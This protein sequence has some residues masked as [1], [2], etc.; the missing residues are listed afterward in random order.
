MLHVQCQTCAKV[1]PVEQDF[2]DDRTPCPQCE[3]PFAITPDTEKSNQD[4]NALVPVSV[5]EDEEEF[6]RLQSEEE[7]SSPDPVTLYVALPYRPDGGVSWTR[8]PV[9]L[10]QVLL[11]GAVLGWLASRVGAVLYL[12]FL[13]PLIMG[14]LLAGLLYAGNAWAKIRNPTFAG[15]IGALGASLAL[16][17][18]HYTDYRQAQEAAHVSADDLHPKVATY[19]RYSPNFRT[20]L[21]ASAQVGLSI[22]GRSQRGFHLGY[23]GTW[24]YWILEWVLVASLAFFGGRHSAIEPY[25]S[26]CSCW[27]REKRFGTLRSPLQDVLTVLQQGRLN[28]LTD[29]LPSA[30][31]GNVIVHAYV[32]PGCREQATIDVAIRHK[33]RTESGSARNEL[34]CCL[35]YPGE[36]L[37][38]LERAF[39]DLT[40]EKSRQAA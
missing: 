19:L 31:G 27:K 13:F 5:S 18:M 37:G 30:E 26:A 22:V 34:V 7:T 21:E 8:F 40:S 16:V 4:P 36:A 28:Q 6:P 20:Y 25:C 35:T 29:Q 39:V 38:E 2:L 15:M 14:L 24:S 11:A 9:F 17:T 3:Q 23:V 32:C 1:F 33:Y 10:L 12:I